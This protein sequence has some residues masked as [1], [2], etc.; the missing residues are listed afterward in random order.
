MSDDFKNYFST[1]WSSDLTPEHASEENYNLN[2][3]M[4]PSVHW[5]TIYNTQDVEA[6]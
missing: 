6:T 3:Y 2:R 1:I 4:H 5:G